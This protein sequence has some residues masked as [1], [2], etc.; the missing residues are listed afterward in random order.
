M[1][2][3]AEAKFTMPHIGHEEHLCYLENVRYI[4]SNLEEY[5][6]LI[7]NPKFVCRRCGRAAA[8]AENLCDPEAL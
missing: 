5:K 6:K 3:M 8:K 4:D 2:R 7:R 1:A